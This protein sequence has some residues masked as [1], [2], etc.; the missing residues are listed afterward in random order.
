MKIYYDLAL[1][2]RVVTPGQ[3]NM[4]KPILFYGTAPA[5]EICLTDN[6][7]VP[8]LSGITA[9]RA[10][11][12]GDFDKD[13]VPVCRSYG[14]HIDASGI[15]DG[16]IR[17]RLFARTAEFLTALSGK[18][19]RSGYFE[20]QG[21]NEAG[22]AELVI[23]I[24]INLHAAV[25][26]LD[27]ETPDPMEKEQFVSM[28]DL[29]AVIARLKTLEQTVEGAANGVAAVEQS[30]AAVSDNVAA[31]E[32]SIA[33]VTDDVTAVEQSIAG[34]TDNVAAVERSI[35]AVSDNVAAV[36]QSIAA[37]SD[38]VAAVE[39][40]IAGE[41]ARIAALEQAIAGAEANLADIIGEE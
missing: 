16:V 40:S 37:V 22:Y 35:A 6:G 25:D 32:R 5:W 29:A 14:E 30:I 11:V 20:L 24:P 39:Q 2:S 13:T 9:W 38:N 27:A 12:D 15:A 1:Q 26:P 33:G 17:V 8:D 34:V 4:T 28:A 31:V 10:A 18:K 21:M 23:H 36:E 7:E 41:D 19:E 3:T